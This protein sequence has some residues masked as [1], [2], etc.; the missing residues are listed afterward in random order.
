[1]KIK[2]AGKCSIMVLISAGIL[3]SSLHIMS[4]NKLSK[5]K[6]INPYLKRKFYLSL[7]GSGNPWGAVNRF[8]KHIILALHEGYSLKKIAGIYNIPENTVLEQIKKMILVSLII[9]KGK[10]YIPTFFIADFSETLE[11]FQEAKKTGEILAK[12]VQIQWREIKKTYSRLAIS[13]DYP[14]KQLNFLLVGSRILDLGLLG[15]LVLDK[16]LITIAPARPSPDR[17]NARYYF[18]G[19]EGEFKH[20][21]KYGQSDWELPE[22]NWYFETFGASWIKGKP[23]YNRNA[24]H[25]KI[26]HILKEGKIRTPGQIAQ[27]LNIPCL[28]KA[29]SQIWVELSG[30][31]C[32]ELL[33]T[34]KSQSSSI[35]QF[36]SSLKA[37]QYTNNSFGEFMCWYTHLAYSRAIDI[38]CDKGYMILP[39]EY[40]SAIIF[41]REGFRRAPG[42]I[43]TVLGRQCC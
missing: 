36:F 22:K 23:N 27:N 21:G 13:K 19:V 5:V 10:S 32:A 30:K 20:L 41:F 17:P 15:A 40:Y 39:R 6:D 2:T 42:E 8:N 4:S 12:A 14:F 1:M 34:I 24:L 11:I 25:Q 28:N 29:D 35:K 3:V 38:L 33:E 16:T 37:G 9:K 31:V 7:A 18:W 43:M 26:E